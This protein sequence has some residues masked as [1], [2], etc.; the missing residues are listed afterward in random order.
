MSRRN[1]ILHSLKF[2]FIALLA[3]VFFAVPATTASAKKKAKHATIKIQTNPGGLLLMIDGKPRGETTTDYRAIDLDAGVHTVQVRLPNGQFWTR[4]VE[5]PAGRVKCVVVNYRPLPPLP[6]SPCPFPVN[7]SAPGQVT[8]GEIITF[9]ADVAYSGNAPIKYT[10]KVTPSSASIISGVGTSTLNVDSTGLGGQRITATL[11]TDDGSSDP[12]CTQS[13]QAVATVAPLKKTVLVAREFDECVNCT[14]DDQKARLDNLAVELQ[15]DPTTRA[16]IIAYGGRMSPV[17]QVEKLMTRAKDY[18]IKQRGI[19]ASR[20]T[21]VNGGYREE[22]SVELWVVPS[23]AAAPQA[24]PTVQ[25]G[26]I[27]RKR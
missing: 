23:G 11:T 18:I 7:I 4:E 8:E 10:W 12:A 21:V 20:L 27:K 1:T 19:D 13:A 25:A 26:E 17:G 16:Y 2:A 9:T 15:N 14:F 3:F 5:L 22:D 6:K 24:T